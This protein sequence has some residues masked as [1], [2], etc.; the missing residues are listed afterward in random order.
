M[1]HFLCGLS[2]VLSNARWRVSAEGAYLSCGLV[3]SYTLTTVPKNKIVAAISVFGFDFNLTTGK[4]TYASFKVAEELARKYNTEILFDEN[5]LTP[6]FKYTDEQGNKHEVWFEN[7]RSIVAKIRLAWQNG[8][9]GVALWR[10]GMEDP[11]TWSAIAR[12]VVVKKF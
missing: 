2:R 5:T 11:D 9:A 8:I 3:L 6:M 7:S 10:L 4:N 12:E 1:S